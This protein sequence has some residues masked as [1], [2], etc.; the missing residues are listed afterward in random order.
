LVAIRRLYLFIVAA[1]SLGMLL[2]GV[3][4][5]GGALI[6]L[7][8]AGLVLGPGFRESFARSGGHPHCASHL[9]NPLDGGPTAGA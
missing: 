8:F 7:G 2:W 1:A 9:G 3:S 5:L 6:D 4:T